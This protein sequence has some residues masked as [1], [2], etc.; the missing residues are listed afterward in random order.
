[1][2]YVI[3]ELCARD[4]AC[5]EVCPVE[6]IVAGPEDHPEWGAAYWIDPDTCIDCGACAPECPTD[7][8]FPE[9]EVPEEYSD[10]PAKNRR[11]YEEG[12]GYEA[13]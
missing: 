5:A 4:G 1:M 6:C 12:P 11:Y 13:A 9:D 3:T 7:A 10:W 2:P 8:I